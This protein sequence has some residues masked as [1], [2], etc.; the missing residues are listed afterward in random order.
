[1]TGRGL[2]FSG[3]RPNARARVRLESDENPAEGRLPGR[4]DSDTAGDDRRL[5]RADVAVENRDL[6]AEE[7]E[8]DSRATADAIGA[9]QLEAVLHVLKS[10]ENVRR[11]NQKLQAAE[12]PAVGKGRASHYSSD[13]F[14]LSTVAWA[15]ATSHASRLADVHT[16]DAQ[17]LHESL[18]RIRL[19]PEPLSWRSRI[20]CGQACYERTDSEQRDRRGEDGVDVLHQLFE[21][22]CNENRDAVHVAEARLCSLGPI[23]SIHG[24]DI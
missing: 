13:A 17:L 1:M 12:R 9:L 3:G 10:L 5:I 2:V 4:C 15:A 22:P 11:R 19:G 7:P 6:A 16:G 23:G 14:Q 18:L 20:R 21:P 24:V 8:T